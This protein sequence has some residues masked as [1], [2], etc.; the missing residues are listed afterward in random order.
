[1][2]DAAKIVRSCPTS[3][4]TTVHNKNSSL[5]ALV[6]P[7]E[8]AQAG[9]APLG[10]DVKTWLTRR[11]RTCILEGGTC[12]SGY[13]KSTWADKGILDNLDGGHMPTWPNME[14]P[15]LL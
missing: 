5:V 9:H 2:K 12:P 10:I 11:T 4:R 7:C 3:R 13:V 6:K 14:I 15:G 8:D 1:M